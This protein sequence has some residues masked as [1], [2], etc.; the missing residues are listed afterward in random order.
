MHEANPSSHPEVLQFLADDF[1]AHQFDLRHLIRSI[2]NSRVYQ[3]S[4][5]YPF[6]GKRP[7]E[8]TFACSMVRPLSGQQLA[9][10]MLVAAGY[11]DTLK[12]GADVKTRSDPG[13]LR[14]KLEAQ[15]AATLAG[16]VKNLDSGGDP[17]QPGIREALYEA[18]SFAFADFVAKGGLPA[19]LASMKG[20][21]PMLQEAFL[22]VLSRLSS[23]IEAERLRGYLQ[24]RAERRQASCE[25]IVWVLVTSAEFRF[26]H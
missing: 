12:S 16:L 15:H 20:D 25:Q 7:E 19:R 9:V 23:P 3:L 1:V 8:E 13:A 24:E 18:N 10:S 17:Y 2:A 6:A 5:R 4:N 21:V 14:A 22:C 11:Y 26:N